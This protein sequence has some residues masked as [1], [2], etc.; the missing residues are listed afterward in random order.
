[1]PLVFTIAGTRSAKGI[2]SIYAV[3]DVCSRQ[4]VRWATPDQMTSRFAQAVLRTA[5]ARIRATGT[6]IVPSDCGVQ[7]RFRQ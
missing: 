4:I 5:I 1:M 2:V 7:A 3:K 6:V